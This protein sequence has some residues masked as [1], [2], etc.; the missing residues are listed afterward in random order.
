M[1]FRYKNSINPEMVLEK[2][3]EWA[4]FWAD[5]W[6]DLLADCW[7]GSLGDF[8]LWADLWAGF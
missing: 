4:D 3:K 1:G 2:S 7:A 5:F 8:D 6:A